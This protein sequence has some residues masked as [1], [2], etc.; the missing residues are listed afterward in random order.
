MKFIPLYTGAAT[1]GDGHATAV[2]GNTP[3]VAVTIHLAD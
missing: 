3:R 1:A 2:I